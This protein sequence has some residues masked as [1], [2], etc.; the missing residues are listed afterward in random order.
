M[1]TQSYETQKK[2]KTK[3]LHNADIGTMEHKTHRQECNNQLSR[4]NK[5]RQFDKVLYPREKI[6][7]DILGIFKHYNRTR[8]IERKNFSIYYL[9]AHSTM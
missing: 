5:E 2:R 1:H 3:V 4:H 9:R 8:E 6:I 7:A